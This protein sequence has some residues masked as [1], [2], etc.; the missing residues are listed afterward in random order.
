[1]SERSI[2]TLV[3]TD[4]SGGH[5][6]LG[7]G[8]YMLFLP[9]ATSPLEHPTAVGTAPDFPSRR[10]RK[11]A[12]APGSPTGRP[13]HLRP[14]TITGKRCPRRWEISQGLRPSPFAEQRGYSYCMVACR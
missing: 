13:F 7:Q 3:S 1:M 8:A 6:R 12:S 5:Y 4:W 14:P 9:M 2:F 10:K 11:C